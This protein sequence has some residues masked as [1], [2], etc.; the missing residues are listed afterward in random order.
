MAPGTA[1]VSCKLMGNG[2]EMKSGT[3]MATPVVAGAVAVL[4]SR[5]PNLKPAEVKLRLYETSVDTGK[6]KHAQ[7]W[8]RLDVMRL[9]R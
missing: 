1:I 7:G 3:S 5:Y 9:I 2:Y 8:G 4:L 6:S